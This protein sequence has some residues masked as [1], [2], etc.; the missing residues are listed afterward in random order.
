MSVL[1]CTEPLI[2]MMCMVLFVWLIVGWC[3]LSAIIS[4]N[5]KKRSG[6]KNGKR[7]R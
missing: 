7:V 6:V 3:L 1:V 4:K 2:F 5:Y